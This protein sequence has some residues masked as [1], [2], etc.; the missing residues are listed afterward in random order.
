MNETTE[1]EPLS[2]SERDKETMATATAATTPGI[3]GGKFTL[4]KTVPVMSGAFSC[5]LSTQNS[6]GLH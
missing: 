1:E 2:S 5:M 3:P 6:F 4:I